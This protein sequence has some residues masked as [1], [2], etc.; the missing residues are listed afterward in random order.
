[1]D[2]HQSTS[3]QI[4]VLFSSSCSLDAGVRIL[5]GHYWGR[6]DA[7]AVGAIAL[8]TGL[9]RGCA[10]VFCG[11]GKLDGMVNFGDVFRDIGTLTEFCISS[12]RGLLWSLPML[13]SS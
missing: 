11:L 1:M 13:L 12:S 8:V 9:G 5:A 10:G 7:A 2:N 3:P 4:I 6:G